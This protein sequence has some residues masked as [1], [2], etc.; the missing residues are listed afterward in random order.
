[1]CSETVPCF[2]HIAAATT[3]ILSASRWQIHGAVRTVQAQVSP[4]QP[5]M[6]FT[7]PNEDPGMFVDQRGNLHMLTYYMQGR[8][9][10]G[11]NAFSSVS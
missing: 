3:L 6:V 9:P 11:Q 7:M 8:E 4:E 10:G 2:S 1:M 5:F